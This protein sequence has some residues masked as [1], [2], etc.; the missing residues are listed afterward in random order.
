MHI[1]VSRNWKNVPSN[2]ITVVLYATTCSVTDSWWGSWR[3]FFFHLQDWREKL[4]KNTFFR[5]VCTYL[6][7]DTSS[8]TT[9]H[10]AVL[11]V[12]LL[13]NDFVCSCLLVEPY[14][15]SFQSHIGFNLLFLC[16]AF[17]PS[18]TAHFVY[19]TTVCKSVY[20]NH[21]VPLHVSTYLVK[22]FTLSWISWHCSSSFRE[23]Y[24]Y[25]KVHFSF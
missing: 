10:D 24:E 21:K 19:I 8:C 23:T 12:Y 3:K 2:E 6:P 13:Q 20:E 5:N 11:C 9:R 16:S 4:L 7:S 22:Y 18:E 17:F 14:G 25:N 15:H 1:N